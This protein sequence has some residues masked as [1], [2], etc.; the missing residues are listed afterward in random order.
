MRLLVAIL[1]AACGCATTR[2]V[3]DR[4]SGFH[5]RQLGAHRFQVYLPAGWTPDQKW[6]VIVFLHGGDERGADGVKPTQVGL[7][8]V[9]HASGGRFPFIVV[10]PQCPRSSFWAFPEMKA[11]VLEALD[12]TLRAF[13]GDPERV[14][15]TGNSMGGFGTWIIGAQ[16]PERFAALVPIC[17]G[18]RPPR[19]GKLPPNAPFRDAPDRALA[20]AQAIGRV[21]VWAF[22]G[23]RDL[24]VPVALSREMVDALRRTGGDVRYTEY[25]ELGHRS[26]DRAYGDEA[27]WR[28]LAAQRR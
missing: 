15:L 3:P 9:A 25:P 12:D 10:F 18:V 16:H 1:L 27:L 8:P 7:G 11:R 24:I 19:G 22:H 28:W 13:S 23:A 6:P 21:P 2:F 14:Y 20:V 17:G 4:A 5:A 26:W